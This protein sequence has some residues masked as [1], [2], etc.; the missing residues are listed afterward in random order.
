MA[1][2]LSNEFIKSDI[3]AKGYEVFSPYPFIFFTFSDYPHT[4]EEYGRGF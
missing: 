2:A 1:N 4:S 3:K